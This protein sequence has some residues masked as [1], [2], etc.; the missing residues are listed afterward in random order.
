MGQAY[1]HYAVSLPLSA[2]TWSVPK[3]TEVA[4][5]TVSQKALLCPLWRG[6]ELHKRAP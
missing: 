1:S 3:E 6:V 2:L 4:W 5:I